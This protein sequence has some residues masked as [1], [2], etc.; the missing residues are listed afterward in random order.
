VY[1]QPLAGDF[2]SLLLKKQ[3]Q[4]PEPPGS[5]APNPINPPYLIKQRVSSSPPDTPSNAVLRDPEQLKVTDSWHAFQQE[6]ILHNMKE[7]YCAVLDVHSDIQY[8]FLKKLIL[9]QVMRDPVSC[10]SF[11][12]DQVQFTPFHGTKPP[13]HFSFPNNL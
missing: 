6:R 3:F 1:K 8:S 7:E 12:M 13:Q 10:L 4:T 5:Y 9:T 11:L 2:I